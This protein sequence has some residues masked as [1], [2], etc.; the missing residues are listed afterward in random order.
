MPLI[1]CS[2]KEN[3]SQTKSKSIKFRYIVIQCHLKEGENLRYHNYVLKPDKSGTKATGSRWC[4]GS[5]RSLTRWQ[6]SYVLSTI[7][8]VPNVHPRITKYGHNFLSEKHNFTVLRGEIYLHLAFHFWFSR[9]FNFMA[10]CWTA[11][12]SW[13][14][15]FD[16]S[17][18][19]ILIRYS[20]FI[21]CLSHLY[22]TIT[23]LLDPHSN[24]SLCTAHTL[25]L[26]TLYCGS[27]HPLPP[28]LWKLILYALSWANLKYT[29]TDYGCSLLL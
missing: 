24:I 5:A 17:I 15:T 16:L 8:F 9:W 22:T 7:M 1:L 11:L 29:V 26:F 20:R 13:T 6:D 27:S 25:Q 21:V 19:L 14:T 10:F 28:L 2:Y 3:R 12:S 4:A 18:L 23:W